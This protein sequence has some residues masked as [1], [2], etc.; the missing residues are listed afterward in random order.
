MSARLA[1]CRVEASSLGPPRGVPDAVRRIC[2]AAAK[3]YWVC[4]E[5]RSAAT[6]PIDRIGHSRRRI[7]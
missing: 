7:S 5:F 6:V 3:A 1:P 2:G 4:S